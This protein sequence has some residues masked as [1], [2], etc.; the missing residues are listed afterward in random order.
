MGE[1]WGNLGRLHFLALSGIAVLVR[2]TSDYKF[3][4]LLYLLEN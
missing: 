4:I 3:G 1:G 2:G